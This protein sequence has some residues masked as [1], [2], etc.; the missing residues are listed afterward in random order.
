MIWKLLVIYGI[1][2]IRLMFLGQIVMQ[3]E[4]RIDIR[5]VDDVS[6][7]PKFFPVYDD[8]LFSIKQLHKYYTD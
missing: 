3:N 6:D 2:G 4:N 5:I 7:Y 1:V 8:V